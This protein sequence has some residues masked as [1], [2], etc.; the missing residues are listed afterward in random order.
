[1]SSDAI[2]N[3]VIRT[4]ERP[5]PVLFLGAG[6]GVRA[7]YP[8]WHDYMAI[9]AKVCETWGDEASA[10]LIRTRA[11]RGKY[12]E[13]AT[14]YKT[15]DVIPTGERWKNLALPFTGNL[16]DDEKDR[17]IPLVSLP[18]SAVIT[19]NYDHSLHQAC[20]KKGRWFLPIELNDET[21]HGTTFQQ[22]FFIARIH[23]RADVPQ[24][25][26]LSTDDY[27]NLRSN[28]AYEDFVLDILRSRT[29]LFV[30]FSFYDPA[31]HEVIQLYKDRA[32]PVFRSL[33]AAII[34][35]SSP[36][37]AAELRSANIEVTSYDPDN[38]HATLWSG[39]RQAF[40][41]TRIQNATPKAVCAP[42]AGLQRFMAFAYAQAKMP[43]GRRR[44]AAEVVEDG[45][46]AS[47]LEEQTH[48][49]CDIESIAH[50][51]KPVLRLDD[52]DAMTVANR[53]I[54]RLDSRRQVYRDGRYI[55]LRKPTQS[56]LDKD[57]NELANGVS[58]RVLVRHGIRLDT[59]ESTA[60]KTVLE[61]CLLS[62]AWDLAAH[63]AGTATGFG[64][65]VRSVVSDLIQ[66]DIANGHIRPSTAA[67]L[68]SAICDLLHHPESG[69][70]QLLARLGRAAFGLQLVLSTPR[71]V[72][73][74]RFALPQQLYLDANVIMPAITPGHPLQPTYRKALQ[75]LV[76]A[77]KN[78]G[79]RV[80]LV[81][82]EQ[83]LNEIVN[84][85]A[86]AVEAV[87]RLG[88]ER[89]DTLNRH[90]ALRGPMYTN[91]FIGAFAS[92][93]DESEDDSF[94]NFLSE[95]APYE[96]EEQLAAHLKS[97]GIQTNST[98]GSFDEV[99]GNLLG[100]YED[101]AKGEVARRKDK[102]LIKH[103]AQQLSRLAADDANGIRSVF[104]TAD[105]RLRRLLRRYPLLRRFAGMTMTRLGLVAMVDVMVGLDADPR[106]LVRLVWATP[107]T[108]EQATLLEYFTR[109][110]LSKY[111]EGTAV[112]MQEAARR[113]ADEMGKEMEARKI[114]VLD[115]A[116][117]DDAAEANDLLEQYEENFF[118]YWREAI[119]RRERQR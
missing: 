100:A 7:G 105:E 4:L 56:P 101:A 64:Q 59:Q 96:S 68:E 12:P 2:S 73:F 86:I 28:S 113:V 8:D 57:L 35:T 66:R 108:D 16:S 25:M 80:Q 97:I 82:E 88:L 24:S 54:E 65:D 87:Q 49:N 107:H 106:S 119:E 91:V 104:V 85:R 13:A 83:F 30:G 42:I 75:R 99:F 46:V 34:P 10:T 71:Q 112:E 36:D 3:T 61:G 74:Q 72:L 92:V 116:N 47:L 6:V 110:G 33:H 79:S 26:V 38:G 32:G 94:A 78:A 20:V 77:G 48:D 23:G 76:E 60:A 40:E 9:L 27:S 55:R 14:V 118:R 102:I 62:R 18:F 17:L 11:S 95:V 90:I 58:D 103:E 39:I 63:Y 117:L 111:D 5:N 21:I 45:I 44:G 115:N 29:C 1:M 81:V 67:A 52:E 98:A 53:S 70:A 31:V 84:H 15:C 37:L 43:G 41:V 50:A 22:D 93:A 114:S 51:L 69:Q 109:V 19:T 89:A